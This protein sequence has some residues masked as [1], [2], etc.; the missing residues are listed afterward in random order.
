MDDT[1][2]AIGLDIGTTTISAVVMDVDT[3]EILASKTIQ[4]NSFIPGEKWERIQDVN[5]LVFKAKD[6]LDE[7]L[8]QFPDA[9]A[10]GLTGQMH[11]ILYVSKSGECLSPLYTW[12]DGSGDQPE[13]DGESAASLIRKTCGIPA[14]TGYGL[15]TCYYHHLKKCV[16]VDTAYICTISDYFGMVLTGRKKPKV[17]AGNAASMGFFD[18]KNWSFQKDSLQKIGLDPDI[19]PD[20]T[21]YMDVLGTYRGI[22]VT[23][24]LGDN[25]ASF[26]GS[27]GLEEGICQ[28]NVGTGGQFSILSGEYFEAP[29]IEARPFLDNK[30][31]LTGSVLCGGRAYAILEEF[32]R[33]FAKEAGLDEKEQYDVMKRLAEKADQ[34]AGGLKMVTAFQGKRTDPMMRGS[35]TNISEDNFRPENLI[36]ATVNGIAQE[37]F[38][39]YEVIHEGTGISFLKLVATGNGVR[40]NPALQQSLKEIFHAELELSRFNEEAACG[41]AISSSGCHQ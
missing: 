16:P 41:A 19:L 38:D 9:A 21:E 32:F 17:S 37:F 12:E 28:I 5:L 34:N 39:I 4:N 29:G 40:L 3:R 14:A 36:R 30:Y 6:L 33:L 2:K 25:Q 26:L 23:V 13:F 27:V 18:A 22:P 1:T 10:I 7:L 24:S 15:V 8:S 11:G 31:L 35:L 20:V